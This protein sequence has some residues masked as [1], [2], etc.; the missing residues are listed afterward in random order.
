MARRK[1]RRGRGG[2]TIPLAPVIGLAAGVAPAIEAGMSG[3][4]DG[5][6]NHLKYAYLGLDANNKFNIGY[7]AKGLLPLVLGLLVHK[8]VGGA[9]LNANRML[10]RARVPLLRV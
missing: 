9:P 6:V 8:F 3:N 10:A 1:R 5:A 7:M 4:I 2:F